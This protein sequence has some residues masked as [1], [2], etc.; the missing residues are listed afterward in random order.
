MSMVEKIHQNSV[1]DED[2]EAKKN[3]IRSEFRKNREKRLQKTGR[4]ERTKKLFEKH[5]I[6]DDFLQKQNFKESLGD[7]AENR[8]ENGLGKSV[9]A[10][11]KIPPPPPP[12]TLPPPLPDIGMSGPQKGP[13]GG[14]ENI[15][16]PTNNIPPPPP[17]PQPPR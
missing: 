3:Q 12:C 16:A 14:P 11:R 2:F 1:V 8:A 5:K 7:L 13:Q 15:V 10:S 4:A 9:N 17:P 6:T